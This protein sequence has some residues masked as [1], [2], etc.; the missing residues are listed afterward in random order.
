MPR[1]LL[2]SHSPTLATGYGRVIRRLAN[3]F[4]SAGAEITLVGF[5][6]SGESHDLPYTIL[7][8]LQH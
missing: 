3:T 7:P 1:L 4:H 8:A 5:G 2:I 6:Y